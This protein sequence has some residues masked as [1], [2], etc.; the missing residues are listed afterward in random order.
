MDS[1]VFPHPWTRGLLPLAFSALSATPMI[2]NSASGGRRISAAWKQRQVSSFHAACE[3][4]NRPQCLLSQRN[5][6][7]AG[8]R[9]GAEIPV[10]NAIEA[11]FGPRPRTIG[12]RRPRWCGRAAP[13]SLY[14]D[15]G[16][17]L[18]WLALG[19][20]RCG[21]CG[22]ARGGSSMSRKTV[23]VALAVAVVAGIALGSST[24]VEAQYT[25]ARCTAFP[26][27]TTWRAAAASWRCASGRPLRRCML[28]ATVERRQG[29]IFDRQGGW[30]RICSP[31]SGSRAGRIASGCGIPAIIDAEA[32]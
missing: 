30:Y 9:F 17:A 12:P 11:V 16:P 19:Q 20:H 7:R 1:T 26:G 10:E 5:R 2:A 6:C 14:S 23:A 22:A 24:H 3:R 15:R 27:T 21:A 31:A 13:R 28:C 29:Q 18:D 25:K 4:N 8:Q 32:L